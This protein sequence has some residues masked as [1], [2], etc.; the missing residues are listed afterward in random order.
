MCRLLQSRTR[1]AGF[2]TAKE[3]ECILF[4]YLQEKIL[5]HYHF[6]F[7]GLQIL[8]FYCKNV[9]IYELLLIIYVGFMHWDNYKG[10]IAL[11]YD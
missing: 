2:V 6:R 11:I 4:V 8:L 1:I 10:F 7:M 9:N 3:K 5:S